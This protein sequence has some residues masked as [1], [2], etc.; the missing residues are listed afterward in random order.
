M[1]ETKRWWQSRGIWF[2]VLTVLTAVAQLFG[3]DPTNAPE[4]AGQLTTVILGIGAVWG[5]TVATKKIE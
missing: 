3:Y 1:N 2:G 5:R 4:W